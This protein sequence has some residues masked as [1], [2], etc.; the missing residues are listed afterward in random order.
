[1]NQSRFVIGTNGINFFKGSF[2]N[3]CNL[4]WPYEVEK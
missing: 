2:M 3:G 1:M 4:T